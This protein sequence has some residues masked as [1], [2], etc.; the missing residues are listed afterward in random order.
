LVGQ[1][2]HHASKPQTK[3]KKKKK[4]NRTF[5]SGRNHFDSVKVALLVDTLRFVQPLKKPP[6]TKG[7]GL[8]GLLAVCSGGVLAG[9][10][11]REGNGPMAEL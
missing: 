5:I 7:G 8:E 10:P 6:P 3:K 1:K 9:F 4:K 11:V 2:N